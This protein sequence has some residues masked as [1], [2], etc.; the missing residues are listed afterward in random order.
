MKISEHFSLA[1]FTKS[2]TAIRKGI[3]NTP[4]D[5]HINNLTLVAENILEPVRKHFDRPVIVTSGYRSVPLCAAIG[6]SK[7]SQHALGQAVDFEI[8]GVDNYTTAAYIYENLPFDQLILEY[9]EAGEPSSGWVHCSYTTI[10]SRRTALIY[11]GKEYR[12]F[13]EAT[14]M[15]A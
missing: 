7:F 9:Y 1:E 10:N 8:P 14:I 12:D 15:S 2:Q 11:D 13:T 5:V 3:D 6:S 4:S